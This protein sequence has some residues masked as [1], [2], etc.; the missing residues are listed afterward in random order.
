MSRKR[1]FLS[2]AFFAVLGRSGGL[3]LPFFVGLL[4]GVSEKTDAFFF[5]Y[6][7]VIAMTGFFTP[8]FE[9]VLVPA[10]SR[11]KKNPEKVYSL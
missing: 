7:L 6:A 1:P 10:L 5:A 8:I 4:Y 2:T 11:H 9:S 3:V